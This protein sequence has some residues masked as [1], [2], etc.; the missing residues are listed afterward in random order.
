MKLFFFLALCVGLLSAQNGS[1]KAQKKYNKKLER[2]R[3]KGVPVSAE[4]IKDLERR[5]NLAPRA[6]Q[7]TL[8]ASQEEIEFQET[9]K[10][11]LESIPDEFKK[12]VQT[13]KNR[14]STAGNTAA[15]PEKLQHC[16]TCSVNVDVNSGEDPWTK[17][18][19]SGAMLECRGDEN[20][21]FTI[22]RRQ[23]AKPYMVQMGC[24]QVTSCLNSVPD[25]RYNAGECHPNSGGGSRCAHCCDNSVPSPTRV[26]NLNKWQSF[27]LGVQQ[28]WNVTE[29]FTKLP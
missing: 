7:P 11:V 19:Q 6:E 27:K 17:C 18:I 12:F 24:K 2:K 25:W 4:E 1:G 8:R 10:E 9:A 21:C 3:R 15:N 14:V 16:F 23:A 29:T 26:C 5:F 20:S 28:N 22:E 13:E